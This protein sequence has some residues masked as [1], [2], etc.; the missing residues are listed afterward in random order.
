M[1]TRLFV[2]VAC[3]GLALRASAPA[4]EKK[5]GIEVDKEKKTVS[6]DAKI[7][8]R[9]LPVPE[10]KGKI[11]PIEVI[12]SWPH[13]KGRK[14]HETIVTFEV[15]PSEIHKAL[16][17]LGIKAG[18]PILG[19]AKG[20]AE[21]PA[22]NVYIDVPQPDGPAKRLSMDKVLVDSRT[23]AP[24]PKNVR[25]IFTGSKLTQPDPEKDDTVYG[26]DLSGT[27]AV[28][29]PVSDEVVLQ[30]AYTMKDEKLL[31]LETNTKNLPAENT[32][33]KLVIEVAG[34]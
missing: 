3:V 19:E 2:I 10:L 32:P 6:I 7:A 27:F 13:P 1:K 16:E 14:A 30:T 29:F 34:K 11:Y 9:M 21:G 20:K 15:K 24:F 31:R 33:V 23:G 28:I 12:G 5:S 17:S 4:Q 25:F 26:A 18:K 8:P 22:V